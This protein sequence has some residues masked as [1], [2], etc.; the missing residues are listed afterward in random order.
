MFKSVGRIPVPNIAYVLLLLG[1]VSLGLFVATLALG[2]ELAVLA[3]IAL[4]ACLG[5]AV[6]GFRTGARK[7]ARD[8]QPDAPTNNVSIFS[9]PLRR[10]EM[11][12]YLRNYRAMAVVRDDESMAHVPS[13]QT[14]HRRAA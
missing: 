11:D 5:G 10:D 2:S 3:G 13:E 9:T 4:I 7:L 6:A 1:F 8:R 14:S 12:Q